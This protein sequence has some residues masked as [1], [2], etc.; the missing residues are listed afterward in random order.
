MLTLWCP[1]F[2]SVTVL[3]ELAALTVTDPKFSEEGVLTIP[4]S[5]LVG[6]PTTPAQPLFHRT[7]SVNTSKHTNLALFTINIPSSEPGSAG[8]RTGESNG[9]SRFRRNRIFVN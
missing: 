9:V 7:I 5:A 1:A 8:T 2:V 6:A 4:A 3:E